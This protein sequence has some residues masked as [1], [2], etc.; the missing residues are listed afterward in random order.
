MF[1]FG[2]DHLLF[3]YVLVPILG[4]LYWWARGRKQRDLARLGDPELLARLTATVS[5]RGQVAKTAMLL[6]IVG[7]LVTALARPQFGSRVETVRREGRDIII[8]L[9]LSASRPTVS[10]RRSSPSPTSSPV[11][12]APAWGWWRSPARRSSRAR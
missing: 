3:G 10:R 1:R 7:L 12:T 11:S 9:D 8:A 2:A 4:A 5:R 6:V